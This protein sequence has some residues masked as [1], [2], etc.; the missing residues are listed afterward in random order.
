[1]RTGHGARDHEGSEWLDDEAGPL[2]RNFAVTRGRTRPTRSFAMLA[3]VRTVAPEIDTD[4]RLLGP[5]HRSVLRLC[6]RPKVVA[7]LGSELDLPVSVLRV[8]LGDL[9]DHG[10]VVIHEPDRSDERPTI[11]TLREILDGLKAL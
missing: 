6:R 7:D 5:E 1:M 8:L 4:P 11:H 2:V 3:V 10:L 9:L